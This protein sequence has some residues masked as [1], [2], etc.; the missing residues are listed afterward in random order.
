M[1]VLEGKKGLD[2]VLLKNR[3]LQRTRVDGVFVIK[4][5]SIAD[6]VKADLSFVSD[7]AGPRSTI[8][9][10]TREGKYYFY[11]G[12]PY[13]V[14]PRGIVPQNLNCEW[15][16]FP[17]VLTEFM[18][19]MPENRLVKI[20][21]PVK[22]PITIFQFSVSF[23]DL[24]EFLETIQKSDITLCQQLE[25]IQSLFQFEFVLDEKKIAEL[26]KLI[27]TTFKVKIPSSEKSR[28]LE[29]I[30]REGKASGEVIA[31]IRENREKC[32]E[33]LKAIDRITALLKSHLF[34]TVNTF[35]AKFQEKMAANG[36]KAQE[37]ITLAFILS[38]STSFST[39]CKDSKSCA[40]PITTN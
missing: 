32:Q 27:K 35:E 1:F 39:C 26:K 10:Q 9:F 36:S 14:I 37:R 30:S 8:V 11:Y 22:I 34:I 12:T 16:E 13:S 40:F 29:E 28:I 7:I 6:I 31:T 33:S 23:T 2:P 24:P 5:E 18:T 38:E 25:I 15:P 19:S 3:S 17:T 21:D 20:E 4:V